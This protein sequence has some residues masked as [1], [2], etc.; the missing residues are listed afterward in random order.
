MGELG[1]HALN[2]RV[3][4]L[5]EL[6]SLDALPGPRASKSAHQTG[7]RDEAVTRE[8]YAAAGISARPV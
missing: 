6:S 3:K 2:V 8:A 5:R 7:V 1:A 4:Q